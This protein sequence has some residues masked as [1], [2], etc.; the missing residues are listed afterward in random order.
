MRLGDKQMRAKGPG[1]AGSSPGVPLQL[2]VGRV[3]FA[4]RLAGDRGPQCWLQR[5]RSLSVGFWV[6]EGFSAAS[7]PFRGKICWL[8]CCRRTERL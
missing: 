3:T 1:G 6:R 2:P 5:E 7:A 8:W 4:S